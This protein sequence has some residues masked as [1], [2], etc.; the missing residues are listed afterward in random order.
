[1]TPY[2]SIV[3]PVFNS[4][5]TLAKS[6]ESVLRQTDN[7]W[8]LIIVDDGSVDESWRI[9]ESYSMQDSRIKI[10][11]ETNSGPGMARN[12]AIQQAVGEYIGFLDSDD[13]WP[14]FGIEEIRKSSRN[15]TADIIFL[16][17]VI[18]K[19]EKSSRAYNIKRFRNMPKKELISCQMSG[20]LPWGVEK[21]IR[22]S[23]IQDNGFHF[24]TDSV[25]EEAVFSFDVLNKCEVISFTDRAVYFYTSNINGQHKKGNMD[26]WFPILNKMT[27]HLH[28]INCFDDYY[29]SINSFALR[30]LCISLYRISISNCFREAKSLMR[31][32]VKK[33]KESYS[34]TDV[35]KISLDYK[36]RILKF[37]LDLHAYSIIFL[38]SKFR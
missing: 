33:Y 18:V 1:M 24:S 30:A 28:S 31:D 9:M 32:S 23:I 13:Y 36:T 20:I 26:P 3:M 7:S 22:S 15:N 11:R 17:T 34:L 37:L 14:E 6:I 35:D 16:D 38:L 25:G 5:Q 2:I 29:K 10:F 12:F 19:N 4:S 8:E 21:V 27:V